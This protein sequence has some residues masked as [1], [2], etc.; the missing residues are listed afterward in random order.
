MTEIFT[1]Y[2]NSKNRISGTDSKFTYKIEFPPNSTYNRVCVNSIK[3]PKSYNLISEPD[4]Y[5]ILKEVASE[6]KIYINEG[7]CGRRDFVRLIERNMNLISPNQWKYTIDYAGIG[8]IDDG[9]LTFRVTGNDSQP[10]LIMV[11]GLFEQ[12]G[13]DRGSTTVFEGNK[14]RSANQILFQAEDTLFLHSD[15]IKNSKRSVL[16][17]IFVSGSPA[18]SGIIWECQNEFLNCKPLD[19]LSELVSFTLTDEDDSPMN[20]NGQNMVI[21]L[22]FYN[23]KKEQAN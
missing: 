18:F 6:S 9:K 22:S 20:L 23:V 3:I 2:I 15:M 1:A 7:N 16:Q 10:S 21:V 12:L 19:G 5:F 13:F 14:L 8:E 4:N 11:N 17:H